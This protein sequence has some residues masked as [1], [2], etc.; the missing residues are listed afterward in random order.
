M[1]VL[2]KKRYLNQA[3]ETSKFGL[4]RGYLLYAYFYSPVC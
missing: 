3:L 2:G 1:E 4:E